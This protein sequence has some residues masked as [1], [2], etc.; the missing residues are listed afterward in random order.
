MG[1]IEC[2]GDG[3]SVQG[4]SSVDPPPWAGSAP[5]L[6][7]PSEGGPEMGPAWEFLLLIKN[8]HLAFPCGCVFRSFKWAF[9]KNT[10]QAGDLETLCG[11]AQRHFP[12]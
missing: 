5:W 12:Y 6:L 4:R 8:F 11:P 9:Q 3:S 2:L 10:N 1:E 7:G